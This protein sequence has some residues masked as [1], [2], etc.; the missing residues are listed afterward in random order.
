MGYHERKRYYSSAVIDTGVDY[1]HPDLDAN[2]WTNPAEKLNGIDDDRNGYVDDI[3][4]WDFYNNDNNPYDDNG[5][6]THC[7]GTIA[8][9]GNNGIGV[10]GVSWNAKIMPLKFLNRLGSGH[11]D[12]AIDAIIYTTENGADIM[13]N[14]WG[15]GSYSKTL[16]D[17][18]SAANDAGILFVAAAGNANAG[19]DNDVTVLTTLQAKPFQM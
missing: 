1:N 9:E 13:S 17:A 16:E 3:R 15:G 18:I 4:G 10:A 6:G 14:S 7:S 12:D 2:I 19:A 5:H 8:A 11:T